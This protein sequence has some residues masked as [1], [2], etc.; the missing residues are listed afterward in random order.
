MTAWYSRRRMSGSIPEAVLVQMTAESEWS[1]HKMG[2]PRK[3]G[4]S[5]SGARKSGYLPLHACG[6]TRWR[7]NTAPR[8]IRRSVSRVEIRLF[9]TLNNA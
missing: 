8:Q 4:V 9:V 3:D 6:A 2:E 1:V 5:K 7:L